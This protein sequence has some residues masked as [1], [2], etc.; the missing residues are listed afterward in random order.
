MILDS[1]YPETDM[2]SSVKFPADKP[3]VT[4]T[5]PA[6]SLW[7]LEMHNGADTRLSSNF[8][9]DAFLPALD[10]VER[11]WRVQW[12]E[13][14]ATKTKEGGRGALI[15]VGNR[16]QN[17]FFSNGLDYESAIKNPVFF[18]NYYSP[19]ALRLL[20]F[21][22]PTVAALNGHCFAGGMI[23]ALSCDYRVMTDGSK[24]NAWMCMNE[25][26]FG[27]TWPHAFGFIVRA[28]V[29]DAQTV[30]KIALEGHRFTPQEALESRLVDHIVPGD[31]EAVLQKAQQVGEAAAG[32]ARSGA[33]GGI[34]RGLYTDAVKALR[35][36]VDQRSALYDDA[37]AKSRL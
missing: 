6:P 22:I 26:D 35:R 23:L 1:F 9:K 30:R 25:I 27:A 15:I 31:T 12:R 29:T 4:V 7:V 10:V 21:P 33:W 19:M 16:S 11:E 8:I 14:Q 28:K 37:D 5:K 18:P 17:K 20:S 34:R 3:L 13:A 32:H 24:R 2:S 36:E